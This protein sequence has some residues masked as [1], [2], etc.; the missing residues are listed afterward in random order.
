MTNL[1]SNAAS[2]L[3]GTE[4]EKD[5]LGR[6]LLPTGVYDATIDVAYI[7]TS[8][9]G[10][11]AFNFVLDIDGKKVRETTYVTNKK[12]EVTYTKDGKKHALPGYSLVNAIA[13]LT[14]GKEIPSLAFEKKLL[15]LIHI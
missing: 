1:F 13:K 11:K 10:A 8:S 15:S 14:C 3:A 6:S 7:T 12:G 4:K 5:V 9:G 2:E